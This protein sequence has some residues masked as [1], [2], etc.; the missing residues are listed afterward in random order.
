MKQT[1]SITITAASSTIRAAMTVLVIALFAGTSLSYASQTGVKGKHKHTLIKHKTKVKHKQ[2]SAQ[3]LGNAEMNEERGERNA[4]DMSNQW[5]ENHKDLATGTIPTGLTHSWHE[6]DLMMESSGSA[7]P[8]SSPLSAV[9]SIGPFTGDY[10]AGRTRA[11][12]VDSSN[13]NLVFAGG[14][15]GGLWKSTNA[16]G[17]WSPINDQQENLTVTCITQEPPA[18]GHNYIYYAT[19]EPGSFDYG[20]SPQTV[21]GGGVFKSTD[22]GSTF[23]NV[24]PSTFP[25]STWAIAHS[26]R[27][28]NTV[29]VG[30]DANG[31]WNTTNGGTSWNNLN[32]NGTTGT[33]TDVLTFATGSGVGAVLVGKRN[34]GLY[35]Y[36]GTSYVKIVPPNCPAY[37][38]SLG[39]IKLANCKTSPN[40]VYAI[41]D[42]N[43]QWYHGLAAMWKSTDGG[44]TWAAI[45]NMPYIYG[46]YYGYALMLGVNPNNSNGVLVGGVGWYIS[47]NGGTSWISGYYFHDQHG[48]AYFNN[49][50]NFLITDDGGVKQGSWD[51]LSTYRGQHSINTAPWWLDNNFVTTQFW[52][53]DF[54]STGQRCLGITQDDGLWRFS[55]DLDSVIGNL[56]EGCSA[57]ISQ[58]DSQ[59]GYWEHA[60]NQP[61]LE[62][63]ST[64]F[65]RS[66]TSTIF[67]I[68]WNSGEGVNPYNFFQSNYAD[69]YQLYYRTN[70]G[71][72]RTIDSGADW[73]R[74]NSTGDDIQG[75]Q[76]IGCTSTPNPTI[77]FT[78]HGVAPAD[79]FYRVTS[80]KTYTP[81]IP[82]NLSA[83]IP[84]AVANASFGEISV[85][86]PLGV[87]TT[88]YMCTTNYSSIPHVYKV[89]N[90]NSTTPIWT[91]ITGDLP[92]TLAV[93][94]VQADPSNASTVLAATDYG[95][96]YSTNAGTNWLK[97]TRM[98]N[99]M[100]N[101]MQLRNSDRT[102]FLFTQGRGV[103]YCSLGAVGGVQQAS[104][105]PSPTTPQL[106]F[107]LY[108]NPAMEKL[109]VSPQQTLSSS[110][111][112]TIY[113]SDGRMISESA[114]N[115]TGEVNIGSLPSGAYFLQIQDGNRIAKSKFIKQ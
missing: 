16:G 111:R 22:G 91:N 52:G 35:Y 67:N 102:L 86:P 15:G 10:S 31:L 101:E 107:S 42:S 99:V 44:A 106:Q 88:L 89:T 20:H 49:S 104:V 80:A 17:Y 36:N 51:T 110:A 46:T 79:S 1:K 65:Q 54:A 58:Q 30:T 12:M 2:D 74:L 5:F 29:Y 38:G 40:E 28:A 115:P 113:S 98:P 62:R 24:T 32:V 13:D 14:V 69:G 76:F 27:D 100:I 83:T 41:L 75:I 43:N 19:G 112:I 84:T 50:D 48:Y 81:G 82:T 39:A 97:E 73:T 78:S 108:P 68:P 60:W 96:Y 11:V 3:A 9:T 45:P 25:N 61:N 114:W 70:K 63:T 18:L 64:L 56:T 66:G 34:D 47:T 71:V 23:I 93:N 53:G 103:W 33:V 26:M 109:T 7:S 105:A 57:H 87:S 4:P 94:E 92:S 59:L 85:Y 55:P 6:H 90:A 37:P 72:W 8:L 21:P 77:Y 95:L